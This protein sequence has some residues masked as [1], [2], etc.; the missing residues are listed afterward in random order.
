MKKLYS[1]GTSNRTRE[2][3]LNILKKFNIQ[4][5]IDVRRF[6][7]SRFEHFKKENLALFLEKEG[8]KYFG[9]EKN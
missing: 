4:Q 9:G 6:P 7:T 2:E 5:V 1:L 8:I 3:F